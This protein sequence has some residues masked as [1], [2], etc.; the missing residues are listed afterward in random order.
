[1][2][3]PMPAG[4]SRKAQTLVRRSAT[5][6]LML[7]ALRNRIFQDDPQQGYCTVCNT[8]ATTQHVIWEYPEHAEARFEALANIPEADQPNIFEDWVIPQDRC[9]NP[10]K[11]G[12]PDRK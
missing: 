7:P 2:I 4:V 5:N 8:L 12:I 11:A 9:K 6:T 3:F 1:M 10:P